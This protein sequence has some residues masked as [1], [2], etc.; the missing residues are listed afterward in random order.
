MTK[1]MKLWIGV[2][3]TVGAAV[4]TTAV[5]V[6]VVLLSKKDDEVVVSTNEA[7]LNAFLDTL[8]SSVVFETF[9]DPDVTNLLTSTPQDFD[10]E[11]IKRLPLTA[12]IIAKPKDVV[13]KYEFKIKTLWNHSTLG[14]YDFII[15]GTSR[16]V[17]T[18]KTRARVLEAVSEDLN[19]LLSEQEDFDELKEQDGNIYD[20][21]IWLLPEVGETDKSLILPTTLTTIEYSNVSHIAGLDDSITMNVSF[22]KGHRRLPAT[23]YGVKYKNL[24]RPITEPILSAYLVHIVDTLVKS[25]TMI[26][27][28]IVK[29]LEPTLV[30]YVAS[31]AL[32]FT[33]NTNGKPTDISI[34]YKLTE[35][36]AATASTVGEYTLM[37]EV[38]AFNMVRTQDLISIFGSNIDLNNIAADI[39]KIKE[40]HRVMDDIEAEAQIAETLISSVPA[41]GETDESKILTNWQLSGDGYTQ[42]SSNIEYVVTESDETSARIKF[43]LTSGAKSVEMTDV[44]VSYVIKWE[45]IAEEVVEEVLAEVEDTAFTDPSSSMNGWLPFI[46]WLNSGGAQPGYNIESGS[47]WFSM[48]DMAFFGNGNSRPTGADIS[49]QYVTHKGDAMPYNVSL[50]MVVSKTLVVADITITRVTTRLYI[51]PVTP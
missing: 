30:P 23:Q 17:E 31:D 3:S 1:N 35:K 7:D 12:S 8:N 10:E 36:T 11:A 32:P 26:D 20:D 13:L 25:D 33:I 14:T 40:K 29:V 37:L 42:R 46:M 15:Y 41:V 2:G 43:I 50:R 48:I 19:L 21:S 38:R 18:A 5:V 51:L 28:D 49:Y 44:V 24:M 39:A 16:E 22:A 4:V 6:P 27:E 47:V 9:D 45:I 34:Y